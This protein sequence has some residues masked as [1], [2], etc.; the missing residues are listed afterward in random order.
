[1][2]LK[3]NKKHLLFSVIFMC[4]TVVTLVITSCSAKIT[5]TVTTDDTS[6]RDFA[7]KIMETQKS[8]APIE[9]A[10]RSLE[11]ELSAMYPDTFGGLWVVYTPKFHFV[12]AFTSGGEEAAQPYRQGLL[13]DAIEVRTV[14]YSY[15]T[16]QQAQ[17]EFGAA[18]GK[19]NFKFESGVNVM[20][21]YTE[22][23]VTKADMPRFDDAVKAG[24]LLIPECVRVEPVDGLARP[25]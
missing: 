12:V 5:T 14:K 10:G 18:L 23:R 1:M 8:A 7:L 2:E 25:D 24:K 13:T 6:A 3:M 19:L 17:M 22:F 15:R 20:D 4:L 21:N 11:P 9:D 16:L